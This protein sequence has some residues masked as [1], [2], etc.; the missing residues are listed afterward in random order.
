MLFDY[1]QYKSILNIILILIFSYLLFKFIISCESFTDIENE[2]SDVS[3]PSSSQDEEINLQNNN[4]V[5][6]QQNKKVSD[7]VNQDS[8]QEEKNVAVV[9]ESN[10]LYPNE[11][12][13]KES[14]I[15]RIKQLCIGNTCLKEED[16]KKL[17]KHG[18]S[19][20]I[21]SN[22]NNSRLR[23]ENPT[24]NKPSQ[25]SFH[26]SNRGPWNSMQIEKCG[27]MADSDLTRCWKWSEG[28]RREM[29][30]DE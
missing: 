23:I 7:E 30:K 8:N 12:E 19:I 9:Q 5:E 2:T 24:K 3:T 1:S 22:M 17:V 11:D 28:G 6:E 16:V 14:E 26:D 15:L 13:I 29:I 21:K 18:D 25:V 20:T 4:V 27:M 10:N